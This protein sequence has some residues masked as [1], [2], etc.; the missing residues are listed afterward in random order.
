RSLLQ[1]FTNVLVRSWSNGETYQRRVVL[2]KCPAVI[3]EIVLPVVL[4]QQCWVH[5]LSRIT[6]SAPAC[7][8]SALGMRPPSTSLPFKSALAMSVGRS[9]T[10]VSTPPATVGPLHWHSEV[11]TFS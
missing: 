10:S 8:K 2:V 11:G 6:P 1:Q 4:V 5:L 9:T 3:S 7:F